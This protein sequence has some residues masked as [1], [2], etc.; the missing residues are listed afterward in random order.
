MGTPAR[1]SPQVTPAPRL[2]LL[3]S[4]LVA[5]NLRTGFIGLG[6]VLPALAHDLGL[7][8]TSASMLVSVPALMMGLMAVAGGALVDGWGASRVAALGLALVAAGGLRATVGSLPALLAITAAFGIGIGLAQPALPRLM[9]AVFPGRV[10]VATGIYASGMIAGS[11]LAALLT[12][13]AQARVAM[14]AGWRGPL[15]FWG[16]LAGATLLVW[17]IVIRPWAWSGNAGRAATAANIEESIAWSP[18]RDRRVWMISLLFATQGLAYYLLVAWLPAVYDGLGVDATGAGAR[19]AIFNAAMLPSILGFPA[20]SDRIGSRRAPCLAASLL[21]VAGSLGLLLAPTA[22]TWTWVWPAIAGAG[23]SGLFA[24]SLVLP[25][26][27]AP[28]PRL[29]A[30]AGMTLAIGYA[31]SAAGPVLAGVV[32][33]LTGSFEMALLILPLF[34]GLMALLSLLVPELPSRVI[35]PA[36]VD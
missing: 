26:D 17:L 19:F 9:S 13:P 15:L 1:R 3:L 24:L 23:V 32:R 16:A 18:W 10:G 8:N 20:L 34:G 33:D 12:A 11:I 27:V 7:S 5:F 22:A 29:G 35:V 6:P 36:T 2:V 4:W 28:G 30:A 31:G 25:V 21:F 14:M